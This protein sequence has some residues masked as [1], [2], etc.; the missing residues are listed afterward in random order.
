MGD[1]RAD[2]RGRSRR[3]SV[4]PTPEQAPSAGRR[5][6]EPTGRRRAARAARGPIFNGLPSAPI[7]LGIAAI[8]ISA[9]GAVTAGDPAL[10]G[11]GTH[12]KGVAAASALNGTGETASTDLLNDR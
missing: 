7:L 5:R 1:H 3:P 2:R 12:D 8:A 11:A 10:A 4:S 6:A 9:G